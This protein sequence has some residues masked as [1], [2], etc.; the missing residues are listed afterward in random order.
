MLPSHDVAIR[1][2]PSTVADFP[3]RIV[4]QDWTSSRDE[5]EG[6][7]GRWKV[8]LLDAFDMA[9]SFS[10]EIRTGVLEST[11]NER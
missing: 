3:T 5:S 10:L 1:T 8:H 4:V 7:A 6:S 2:D 9:I 11:C